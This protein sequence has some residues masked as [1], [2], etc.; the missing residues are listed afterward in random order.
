MNTPAPG[1]NA[2][3][4]QLVLHHMR[5]LHPERADQLSGVCEFI[6]KQD[7]HNAALRLDLLKLQRAYDDLKVLHDTSLCERVR[8]FFS[9]VKVNPNIG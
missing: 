3:E 9:R 2:V 6:R 1:I 7:N 8:R 5:A 4:A